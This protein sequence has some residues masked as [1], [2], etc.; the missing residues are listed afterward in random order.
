MNRAR[1]GIGIWAVVFYLMP[2]CMS[3]QPVDDGR[4]FG[5]EFR[6]EGQPAYAEVSAHLNRCQ[7][8]RGSFRQE[9]QVA[10][11][12]RPLRSSGAFVFSLSGGCFGS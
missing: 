4:L 2:G 7:F 12:S 5:S 3:A 11:L 9:K 8:V 6:A 10:V 1:L